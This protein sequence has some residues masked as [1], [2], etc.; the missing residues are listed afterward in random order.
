MRLDLLALYAGPD[1]VMTV[2]SGLAGLLGLLLM[3]W[4]KVVGLFFKMIRKIKVLPSPP[5][6]RKIIPQKLPRSRFLCLRKKVIVIGLD[7][8][9][10]TIVEAMLERGE[11]PNL[12]R[13]A[14]EEATV[15]CERLIQHRRRWPGRRS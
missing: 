12:Q 6:P 15:A 3:F 2:T 10:P 4:N 13:S 8:L 7:G 9:E 14:P 5:N 11:L 1:Q